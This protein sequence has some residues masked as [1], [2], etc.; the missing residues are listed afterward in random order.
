MKPGEVGLAHVRFQHL[1]II[2]TFDEIFDFTAGV[3]FHFFQKS[4]SVVNA[5]TNVNMQSICPSLDKCSISRVA[6]R[7]RKL[8]RFHRNAPRYRQRG[9]VA[10]WQSVRLLIARSRVRCPPEPRDW[11]KLIVFFLRFIPG[12]RKPGA[13]P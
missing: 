4:R 8:D 13:K 5:A 6:Y 11:S 12:E 9:S 3:Y 7:C 1:I 2:Q 10:Q